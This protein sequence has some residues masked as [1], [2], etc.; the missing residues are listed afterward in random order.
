MVTE[1]ERRAEGST[2]AEMRLFPSWKQLRREE[3]AAGD[4]LRKKP[5]AE[6]HCIPQRTHEGGK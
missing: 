2:F 4:M 3:M 6:V 1:Q 5:S